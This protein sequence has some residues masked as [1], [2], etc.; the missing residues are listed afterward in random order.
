MLQASD[1]RY[2]LDIPPALTPLVSR[3]SEVALLVE[4]WE[5]ARE[6]MGQVIVVSGEAGIGKSRLVRVLKEHLT[7]ESHV[8]WET[9]ITRSRAHLLL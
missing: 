3:E 9:D 5:Q 6:G 2:R 8:R 4:R 7:A 1:V